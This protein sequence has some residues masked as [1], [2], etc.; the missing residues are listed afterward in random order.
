MTSPLPKSC[1][2]GAGPCGLTTGKALK[3]RG[4]PYDCFDASD[5]VGGNWYFG[6]P[7]GLSSAYRMLH[8][9]S[10]KTRSQFADYPMPAEYPDFPHH[11][12]IL[13]Y[14]RDYA[15]H[16]GLRSNISFRTKVTQCER[17]ADGRWDVHLHTG[18]KKSYDSLFVCNG[19]HWDARWPEPAFPGQ[20]NGRLMHS[21]D[22][23]D[24]EE[25]R[26]KRVVVLGMG[27]SAM[28]ISVECAYVA[29]E[30]YLAAR[31]GAHIVPKYVWGRPL[32]QWVAPSMPYWAIRMIAGFMVWVQI[33]TYKK[34]G[35][36]QPDHRMLEAHQSV[37]TAIYDRLAHGDIG[38]KPNISHFQ[39]NNVYFVDG[40]SVEADV[41]VFCTGYKVT[42]PFFDSSFLSAPDNDLPLYLRMIK[43]GINNLFFMG[44]CQPLGAIFPIAER[45]AILA[46]EYLAGRCA[47]P[48]EQ[49]MTDDMNR[50]RDK[51]LKRY[52]RSKRHTMQVDFDPFMQKLARVMS[53]GRKEATL[54]GYVSPVQGQ[55]E[56]SPT[57][58]GKGSLAQVGHKA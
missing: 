44:L 40:T 21:H 43:P 34:Y 47:L 23:K 53:R 5:N 1:I 11:S 4:L 9:D 39:G 22:Y 33:G 35:L 16:F 58:A 30:V 17:T 56:H 15:D 51:M 50:E 19:H 14:F 20:F 48:N 10:S 52:V 38:I 29:D 41:V 26:G 46:A 55:V 27:N 2:I 31:R 28:D 25:F 54:P 49:E 24:S 57:S 45:Q 8:I 7:N 3:E 13:Q 32:D 12:Q 37:S 18:E 6:N 36:P 42:F